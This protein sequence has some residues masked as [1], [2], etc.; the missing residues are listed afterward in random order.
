MKGVLPYIVRVNEV[1]IIFKYTKIVSICQELPSAIDSAI[2][3]YGNL[4]K[5]Y[6]HLYSI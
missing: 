1:D 5:K 4:R 3:M 6:L 2:G